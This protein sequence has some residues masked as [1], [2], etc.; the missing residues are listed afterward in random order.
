MTVC[1]KSLALRGGVVLPPVPLLDRL[2]PCDVS[3][4][5]RGVGGISGRA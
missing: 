4:L 2:M 5:F 1:V 3:R